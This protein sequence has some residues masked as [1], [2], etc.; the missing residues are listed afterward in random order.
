V[1]RGCRASS[2]GILES[3]DT[4]ETWAAA[5]TGLDTYD[6]TQVNAILFRAGDATLIGTDDGVFV[7]DGPGWLSS[8]S[9]IPAADDEISGLAQDAVNGQVLYAAHDGDYVYRSTD[10]G[11]TWTGT[12]TGL[13]D[14]WVWDVVAHPTVTGE[15]Y[16]ATR[17]DGVFRSTDHG[18]SWAPFNPG[19]PDV[20]VECLAVGPVQGDHLFAGTR[21]GNGGGAGVFV[22][23]LTGIF[24]DGFESGDTSAWSSGG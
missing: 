14:R 3:P 20:P 17:F 15:V 16:L 5:S 24:E 23:S 19:L 1:L 4:G 12:R 9:G 10:G 22:I 18:T 11:A 8:S 13:T 2:G 6:A 21:G 7:R